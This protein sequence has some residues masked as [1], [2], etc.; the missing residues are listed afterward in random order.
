MPCNLTCD[1][2]VLLSVTQ[3]TIHSLPVLPHAMHSAEDFLIPLSCAIVERIYWNVFTLC[4]VSPCK[5][6]YACFSPQLSS[7]LT[8]YIQSSIFTFSTQFLKLRTY[9]FWY[10]TPLCRA[11]DSIHHKGCCLMP[12]PIT[13]SVMSSR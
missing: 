1:I 12:S 3:H 8:T 9:F 11:Q 2:D 4:I 6:I 5:Y 7:I 10:C 13:S